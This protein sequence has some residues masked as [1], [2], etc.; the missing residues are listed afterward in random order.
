MQLPDPSQ[1]RFRVLRQDDGGTVH[2]LGR[3][4]SREDA[5]AV[6]KIFE[7]RGHKQTY[8][9]EEVEGRKT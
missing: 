4:A 6:A 9:V 5:E 3:F 1:L 2:E 7:Q 8:W